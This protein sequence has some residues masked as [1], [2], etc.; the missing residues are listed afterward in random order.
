MLVRL[1]AGQ[2]TSCGYCVEMHGRDLRKAGESDERPWPVAAWR[3]AIGCTPAERA[4]L[5]PAKGGRL[6]PDRGRRAVHTKHPRHLLCREM[7]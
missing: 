2:V 4:A 3:Q 7:H 5:G 1:R 6:R